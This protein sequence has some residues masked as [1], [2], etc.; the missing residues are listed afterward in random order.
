MLQLRERDVRIIPLDTNCFIR[1]LKSGISFLIQGAMVG[2]HEDGQLVR[3]VLYFRNVLE[4][5]T[6]KH[7]L[8]IALSRTQIFQCLSTW[9]II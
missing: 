2:I 3:I 7:L 8:N 6:Q 5:R 4:E 1:E 9:N